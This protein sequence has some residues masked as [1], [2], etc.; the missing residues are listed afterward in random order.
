[1]LVEDK[2]IS[3]A[4]YQKLTEEETARISGRKGQAGSQRVVGVPPEQAPGAAQPAAAAARDEEAAAA[5][6][7]AAAEAL[8]SDQNEISERAFWASITLNPPLYGADT[9]VSF[10][11]EKLVRGRAPSFPLVLP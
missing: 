11:D 3:V 4:A 10:F 8:A 9:P 1:M 2:R 7:A 6:A 5:A